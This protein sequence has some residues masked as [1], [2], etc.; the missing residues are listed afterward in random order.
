MLVGSFISGSIR[1]LLIAS[2]AGVAVFGALVIFQPFGKAPAAPAA[3]TV[4]GSPAASALQGR[5]E[6][7]RISLRETENDLAN[8]KSDLPA[9]AL[10]PNPNARAQYE[11]QIAAAMERR[12]LAL[13][14]AAAIRQ[15]L[16]AGVTPSSLAAIRDSVVIGQLLTQQSA[17][18]TQIAIDGARFRSNHPTM[19]A[20]T[21]QRNSLVTLIRR[22]AASIASA[23]ESEA[24]IDDAQIKLLEGQL[25]AEAA[26]PSAP[27][28]SMLEA[29][30]AAQRTELD[31]LVDAYFN[32]PPVTA[33]V[34]QTSVPA[35]PFGVANLAVVGVAFAAAMLF[36][37]L[38][39]IRRPRR[40]VLPEATASDE[41]DIEA[42]EA[43]QDL[44]SVVA[45]DEATPLRKAS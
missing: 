41:D 13:R 5:I 7:L 42:W 16:D 26:Q 24:K 39:A 31:S 34:P 23:L 2:A 6:A 43:D 29:K 8:V 36:Q 33:T 25:P 20:L 4:T 18:D 9:A 38:L 12:D 17:L 35:D 3:V 37:T 45:V 10:S 14:H 40:P 32:I 11:A 27:D 28:T 1:T 22:E 19:L 44:E 21:A 30:A 15:S